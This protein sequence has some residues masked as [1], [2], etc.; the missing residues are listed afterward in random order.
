MRFG[1]LECNKS[2]AFTDIFV[3]KNRKNGKLQAVYNGDAALDK[4]GFVTGDTAKIV[5]HGERVKKTFFRN[6]CFSDPGGRFSCG[7]G[8]N[9]L[10]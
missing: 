9:F 10:S 2:F 1:R 4:D 7:T 5:R 3:L 6:Y 8:R